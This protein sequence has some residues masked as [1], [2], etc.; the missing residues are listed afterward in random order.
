MQPFN[1]NYL[2]VHCINYY[3]NKKGILVWSNSKIVYRS[4]SKDSASSSPTGADIVE[5]ELHSN[6]SV[7]KSAEVFL[8]SYKNMEDRHPELPLVFIRGL[9]YYLEHVKREFIELNKLKQSSS[10]NSASKSNLENF[11]HT[12]IVQN[13]V[14][15]ISTSSA[16]N[17]WVTVNY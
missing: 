14:K 11:E 8:N 17:R 7:D 3:H 15:S 4:T 16:E 6:E 2:R 1:S 13:I 10:S 9:Y 12:R 5:T